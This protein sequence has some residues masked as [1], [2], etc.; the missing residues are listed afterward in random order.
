MPVS[1]S[2]FIPSGGWEG[3]RVAIIFLPLQLTWVLQQ[4]MIMVMTSSTSTSLPAPAR[5]SHANLTWPP[6]VLTLVQIGTLHGWRHWYGN[7]GHFWNN[8]I[9]AKLFIRKGPKR[10]T[11][12]FSAL[13]WC[14]TL[15]FL[16]IARI[17]QLQWPCWHTKAPNPHLKKLAFNSD[18]QQH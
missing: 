18:H 14:W 10:I 5:H 16:A 2:F 11:V 8:S 4:M 15:H 12:L 3:P 9:T 7:Y 13:C 1:T 6:S 17:P